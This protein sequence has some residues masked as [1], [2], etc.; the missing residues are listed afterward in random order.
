MKWGGEG[1][2]GG[3]PVHG[4]AATPKVTVLAHPSAVSPG[5]IHPL[6][7]QLRGGPA[8]RTVAKLE[9]PPHPP[10]MEQVLG[11]QGMLQQGS[12]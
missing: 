7:F 6:L 5:E 9:S 1:W 8:G 11:G 10:A 2:L 12:L 4:G 3:L